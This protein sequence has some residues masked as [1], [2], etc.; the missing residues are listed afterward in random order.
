MLINAADPHVHSYQMF[1]QF[2]GV[3]VYKPSNLHFLSW[4][5]AEVS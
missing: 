1:L 4:S 5:R 2:T 3:G